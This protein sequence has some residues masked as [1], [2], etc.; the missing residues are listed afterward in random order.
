MNNLINSF[1]FKISKDNNLYYVLGTDRSFSQ[2]KTAKSFCEQH[3]L[4]H[5]MYSDETINL[6]TKGIR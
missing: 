1:G 5:D 3:S 4:T 2:L 6:L